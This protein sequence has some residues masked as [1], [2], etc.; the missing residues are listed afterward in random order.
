MIDHYKEK[1]NFMI[2]IYLLLVVWLGVQ[3]ALAQNLVFEI[4]SRDERFAEFKR[5]WQDGKPVRYVVGS[6]TPQNDWPAYQP[7]AFDREVSRV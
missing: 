3:A 4:G 7:G 1:H 6:S 2:L 5:N